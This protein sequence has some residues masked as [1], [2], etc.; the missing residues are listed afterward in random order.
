[1]STS[2][3]VRVLALGAVA[4]LA[5]SL[6]LV[7]PAS[8]DV[9]GGPG[10]D[11]PQVSAG[12]IHAGDSAPVA[13][14]DSASVPEGRFVRIDVLANDT[15]PDAADHLRLIDT[16]KPAAG[17]ACVTS[18][19]TISYYSFGAP[20]DGTDSFSYSMTDGDYYRTAK[21]TVHVTPTTVAAPTVT[22]TISTS[23][24]KVVRKGEVR[25]TNPDTVHTIVFRAGAVGATERDIHRTIEPGASTV[26][27]TSRDRLDYETIAYGELGPQQD[28]LGLRTGTIDTRTAAV[29]STDVPP[30]TA[31]D[32]PQWSDTI[33]T[34]F[35]G[36]YVRGGTVNHPDA[37]PGPVADT[38][39]VPAG[40]PGLVDVLG[41]DTDPDGDD[42]HLVGTAVVGENTG[43]FFACVRGDK[44]YVLANSHYE[45]GGTDPLTYTVTD[46]DRIRTATIDVETRPLQSAPPTVTRTIT[47]SGARVVRK[48][49]V[50]VTNPDPDHQLVFR[51]GPAPGPFDIRRTLAPGGTTVIE[52]SRSHLYY[53]SSAVIGDRVET[54]EQ[55]VQ[56]GQINTVA[57]TV[58]VDPGPR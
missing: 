17:H 2:Q 24:A 48:G 1:M 18:D 55:E 46:G 30:E 43:R 31:Q 7:A 52:T 16:S 44:V 29:T 47:L 35:C 50:R 4:A 45:T 14:D 26:V 40:A 21:V 32:Q 42:L 6:A 19:D 54:D 20:A 3:R 53:R 5:G 13:L 34:D 27:A 38:G 10:C 51:A 39:S 37:A 11:V 8:A 49:Q 57:G 25:V 33:D 22:R 36:G 23:K 41:N 9:Y 56:S 12:P 15:D 58:R 28:Q